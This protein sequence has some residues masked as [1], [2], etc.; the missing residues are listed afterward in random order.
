MRALRKK[1]GMI[2][3]L[4]F[5]V[6]VL[7]TFPAQVNAKNDVG[8]GAPAVRT[9]SD[10]L[11]QNKPMFAPPKPNGAMPPMGR[12]PMDKGRAMP[13]MGRPP[14]DKGGAKK[15][16]NAMDPEVYRVV[17]QKC[18]PAQG[19]FV[20]N[21]EEEELVNVLR[22]ISDLLC[23][24]F[25]IN[26]AISKNQK[27]TIIGKSL[28]YP[29]E[30]WNILNAAL[31]AKGLALVEQGKTW[32]VIKRN[33]GKN[34][35]TPFYS[36]G[37]QAKNNEEI[38]TLFYKAEH[39]TPEALKNIARFLLSK[40][41][42][43]ET[44]ADSFI[45]VIDSNSN[46]RRLGAIIAQVDIEDALDKIHFI[47]LQHADAKSVERQLRE[48]FEVS[49]V[50][51]GRRRRMPEQGHTALNIRKI[52]ADERMNGILVETDPTSLEKLKEVVSLIDKP[53]SDQASKGKIHVYRLR[54]ADAKKVADTLSSVVQQGGRSRSRFSRRPDLST[55]EL[56][57]GEVR[58]TAHENTNT[59]VTVASANDWRALL[60]TIK[61]LDIRKEQ[62]YVEAV[63][64]DIRVSDK[65]EFGIN[66]FGGYKM[67]IPGLGSSLGILSNPGGRNIANDLK[68]SMLSSGSLDFAGN[69]SVGAL[70]V[71][72]NFL[73][74]GVTGL[75]GP[76]IP[77]TKIPSFGAVLQ[78]LAT[79]SNVDILSTPYLL[80][81]DNQEAVMK[82][83][84]KVP[85]VRGASTVGSSGL[86]GGTIPMQ[87]VTYENVD[88]TLKITP[89]VGADNIINLTVEQ[90]VNELG[91]A[92][93]I[94]GQKQYR[95]NT[96]SAKTNIV[97]RD[98]QTGVIGGLIS[99]KTSK[100]D[101]KIPFLGDIPL[102]G[103]LF[104]TRES[105]N[106]R[107]NLVLVLTPYIIRDES[108]YEE[109]LKK[110][111]KEREEFA[112]LYYGGKIKNYNKSINYNKKAGP[113][114]SMILSVDSEMTKVENG[115]PGDGSETVIVPQEK[116]KEE[117]P[118]EKIIEQPI[119]DTPPL[120]IPKDIEPL[121]PPL[122]IPP[123]QPPALE[124]EKAE[125]K[126]QALEID[127]ES[128]KNITMFDQGDEEEIEE[129]ALATVPAA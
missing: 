38:G 89:R 14:M 4:A 52:I 93:P 1:I 102:L 58:I 123:E 88:L 55:N 16:S 121:P 24:T 21:F 15:A 28:I 56:F 128:L 80:T 66:A 65:S 68:S 78:A 127:E 70:A 119:F 90:E 95:I 53:A 37:L 105:N 76:V 113:L 26:E 115:G 129:E 73:A 5:V 61:S 69:N 42:I 62:V 39:A 23:K 35:Y 32:T 97:L 64:M 30:A 51:Q 19:Q 108:D 48:L 84:E 71:L 110:K 92:E 81:S 45:I 54:Y 85:M 86:A 50:P 6:S 10:A 74:G 104:K 3:H 99:H 109:I 2:A 87:N 17:P 27:F 8:V 41:G 96:K 9:G 101:N 100:V 63:I 79:D 114:S 29:K 117:K 49:T 7:M 57:E 122:L 18:V 47:P 103:W 33:E 40:D 125:G 82:V 98:Q 106:E 67:D 13:P 83:G 126:D 34:F 77:G 107:K 36:S 60:S 31:A 20:W 116:A 124:P 112:E 75:V 46:I 118:K 120:F 72:G 44:I 59:L 91:N 11:R 94:F 22:Q 43:V 12:P 111:L 25:V